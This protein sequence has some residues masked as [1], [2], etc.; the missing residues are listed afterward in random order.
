MAAPWNSRF[1]PRMPSKSA[2]A[3]AAVAEQV[4]V[5]KVEVTPRQPRDLGQRVVDALRV[6]RSAA[7]KERVLVAEVAMLRAAARDD[8]ASWGRDSCGA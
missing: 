2:R 1:I 5:E 8:D 4:V 3:E 6:E 7:G